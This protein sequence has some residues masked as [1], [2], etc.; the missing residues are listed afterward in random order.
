MFNEIIK[1]IEWGGKQLTLTTGKIARQAD[2]AVMVRMGDSIVLCTAVSSKEPKEGVNFFPLT[3]HYRE[4]ASAAG[5]IPGGFFKREGQASAKESLVSRLI[6][7]PIRPLFHASFFN[8][9]QVICTVMSYD[10]E[11]NTDILA[12]IGA[13][14]ALAISG[15]PYLEVVA[16][17][18]VG[19][20][21][22]KF[23]LNPS[24]EYLKDSKLDLVV[25]GTDTSIMMVE[26]EASL[27]T[28]QQML[29]AVKFGHAAFQPVITMIKEL[30]AEVGKPKWSVIELYPAELV[31]QIRQKE[32]EEIKKAFKIQSKQAR[33][34]ALKQI[35]AGTMAHFT[36]GDKFTHLQIELALE[37]VKSAILRADI[38]DKNTRIDDRKPEDIRDISCEVSILPK[39]HGSSLFTRGETQAL[40]VTTL[41]TAQDEQ[42]VDSLDGEYRD[43]FMLN[44]IFPPYSVGETTP[45]RAPGRREI[46]HGKLAWRAINPVLPARSQFPYSFRV[47]SEITACNGSSSMATICGASMALMD[48]GVPLK[49]PIAG[50]AMGLIK[51]GQKSVIL[52]DIIS[53]E[54]YLGDMDFKVAGGYEGITALQM[55]IKV[56]GIDFAL[57]AKALQQAKEGRQH[58]LKEMHKAIHQSNDQVSRYA[59]CIQSFK[60]DKDKIRDVIGAGGKVIREI[61]ETTGAKIDISDDGT[62]SVSAVGKEKME[63]AIERIKS[64]AFEAEIGDV[65]EGKVVKILDAGAFVNYMSNK[66]GFVHISE[67]SETR[68]ESVASVLNYGDVVKVKILGFDKGKAKL[69]IKNANKDSSVKETVSKQPVNNEPEELAN[70]KSSK[71]EQS[72]TI[73]KKSDTKPVRKEGSKERKYFN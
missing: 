58:I 51:E 35:S 1:T 73:K 5:K 70:I 38:L 61:C 72:E 6:D 71:A 57:I 31:E 16:A 32:E 29:E 34:A 9:T 20:V 54:D 59:P 47:V 30:V 36:A 15:V 44:Y 68:I 37:D 52:S 11:C 19:L 53:D 13:S 46:G 25:A 39:T 41:G 40:V 21:D 43:W 26:S 4:M 28:E 60:I 63:L 55:D 18:R 2:G 45:I 62:V 7:R 17:S 12:V 50:I 33:V 56:L 65:F 23:V 69:T 14:A 66:D 42:I 67:I 3:V 27:L 48:A 22:N 49:E 8:E 10:P 64:I 24:F